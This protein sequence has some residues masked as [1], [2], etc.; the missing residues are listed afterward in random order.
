MKMTLHLGVQ[1]DWKF[2][3]KLRC[4]SSVEERKGAIYWDNL[5][6]DIVYTIPARILDPSWINVRG[7]RGYMITGWVSRNY[8][9]FV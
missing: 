4:G 8:K 6:I 1:I 9:L 3:F 2:V 7:L 5:V